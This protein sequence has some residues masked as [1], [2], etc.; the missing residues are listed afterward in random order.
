MMRFT[1]A[2]VLLLLACS[3]EEVT[4]PPRPPVSSRVSQEFRITPGQLRALAERGAI[5]C[6][7]AWDPRSADHVY[8]CAARS[9]SR[10]QPFFCRYTAPRSDVTN[11]SPAPIGGVWA[12][13]SAYIGTSDGRVLAVVEGPDKATSLSAVLDPAAPAKPRHIHTGMTPPRLES[14]PTQTAHASLDKLSGIVIVEAVI[15]SDGSIGDVRVIKPLPLGADKL[16]ESLVRN[17]K[18]EPS[19]FFGVAVPVVFNI[20]VRVHNGILSVTNPSDA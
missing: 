18:F 19:R 2:A 3:P 12:W 16:A 5:D 6:G 14:A 13:P 9:L 11:V 4:F 8:E 17:A 1:A 10:R 20:T 15:R 7:T